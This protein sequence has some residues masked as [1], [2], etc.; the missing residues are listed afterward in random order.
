MRERADAVSNAVNE[1]MER[2]QDAIKEMYPAVAVGASESANQLPV[3]VE[4]EAM[5]PTGGDATLWDSLQEVGKKREAPVIK[6]FE[7]LSLLG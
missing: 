3:G 2:C 5:K 1:V 4:G 6:M 7:K